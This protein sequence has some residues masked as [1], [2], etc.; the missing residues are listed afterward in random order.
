MLLTWN[1]LKEGGIYMDIEM[2]LNQLKELLPA[3]SFKIQPAAAQEELIQLEKE[4]NIN[5]SNFIKEQACVERIPEEVREKWIN[6][7]DTF[8]N[9]DGL[10]KDINQ[11]PSPTDK[12]HLN[13]EPFITQSSKENTGEEYINEYIDEMSKESTWIPCSFYH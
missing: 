11:L 1:L 6:T 8:I 3:E 12:E 4:Y 13:N 7:L 2:M 5:T 10:I 9:F